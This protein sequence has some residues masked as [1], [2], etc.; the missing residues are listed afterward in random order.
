[1]TQHNTAPRY[2]YAL[3]GDDLGQRVYD[4]LRAPLENTIRT[5]LSETSRA[6]LDRAEAWL[7]AHTPM[8]ALPELSLDILRTQPALG[9]LAIEDIQLPT[10]EDI[11]DEV[12]ELR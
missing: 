5:P 7:A 2:P 9:R 11:P 10:F 4:S 6:R 12:V 3:E 8:A 1:M